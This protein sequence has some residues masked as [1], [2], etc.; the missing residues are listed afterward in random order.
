MKRPT[1]RE[2]VWGVTGALALLL[3]TERERFEWHTFALVVAIAAL[4][5]A[6]TTYYRDG[7]TRD[8]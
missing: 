1:T 5:G 3:I 2:F 4:I 7:K 6:A 8:R